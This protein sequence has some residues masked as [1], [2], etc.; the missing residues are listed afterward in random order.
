MNGNFG[1][2]TANSL[3]INKNWQPDFQ[4]HS[5]QFKYWLGWLTVYHATLNADPKVRWTI[6]WEPFNQQWIGWSQ[7][8]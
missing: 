4:L 2:M 8:K 7:A 5:A 6:Y 1:D 3:A